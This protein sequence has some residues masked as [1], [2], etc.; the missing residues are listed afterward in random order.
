MIPA[1]V[2]FGWAASTYLYFVQ[3][4]RFDTLSAILD[5]PDP[6]R[7]PEAASLIYEKTWEH[8]FPFLSRVAFH[9]SL[10]RACAIPSIAQAICA[11]SAEASSTTSTA[12]PAAAITATAGSSSSNSSTSPPAVVVARRFEDTDLLVKEMTERPV[13]DPRAQRALERAARISSMYKLSN[14]E[15]VYILAVMV[16]EPCRLVERWGYRHLANKEKAAHYEVWRAIGMQMGIRDI[17][18]SFHAMEEFCVEFEQRNRRQSRKKNSGSNDADN[19]DDADDADAATAA[20]TNAAID[21]LIATLPLKSLHSYILPVARRLV[22]TMLDPN[23]REA[24]RLKA[25]PV[26][27]SWFADFMLRA[28]AGCVRYLLLPRQEPARR[29]TREIAS[30]ASATTAA[31]AVETSTT[32]TATIAGTAHAAARRYVPIN[33]VYGDF[34]LSSG[35]SIDE[36]GPKLKPGRLRRTVSMTAAGRQAQRVSAGQQQEQPRPGQWDSMQAQRFQQH[37]QQQPQ[38]Q[39]SQSPRM[40]RANSLGGGGPAATAIS[41]AKNNSTPTTTVCLVS[42]APSSTSSPRPLLRRRA[43]TI[44]RPRSM[45]AS[46]STTT[47]APPPAP[48]SEHHHH[49]RHPP[50]HNY[51][52]EDDDDTPIRFRRF[53]CSF[54]EDVVASVNT[55][56]TNK[57]TTPTMIHA[58]VPKR[59]MQR[60]SLALDEMYNTPGGDEEEDEKERWAAF[61]AKCAD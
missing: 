55:H 49:H 53:S 24:L 36:L 1:L 57:T 9:L 39:Q 32:T 33:G 17:P 52:H 12:T 46:T 15:Y 40:Q 43:T 10:L 54:A 4:R 44:S 29:T 26:M 7:S 47:D 59:P 16:V 8:E 41:T 21:L 48:P 30:A 3:G 50:T 13:T 20:L 14:D 35:Y 18:G 11:R 56:I 25:P 60:R 34:Y 37:H 2:P 22:H 31:G 5:A 28:H 61:Y 6:A 45:Y 23:L 19:A 27:L 51:Y 38:Q 42:P 58:P